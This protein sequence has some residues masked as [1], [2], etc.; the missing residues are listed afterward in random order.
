LLATSS[1]FA[2]KQPLQ[3]DSTSEHLTAIKADFT[4]V[5][6]EI[7]RDQLIENQSSKKASNV[8]DEIVLFCHPSIFSTEIF[9]TL[10]STNPV[11]VLL[12]DSNKQVVYRINA[13][14]FVANEKLDIPAELPNGTYFLVVEGHEKKQIRLLKK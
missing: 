10:K 3:E 13:N 8:V 2:Q 14:G 4:S 6:D 1:L 5:S 11:E 9:Y 7:S 12:I